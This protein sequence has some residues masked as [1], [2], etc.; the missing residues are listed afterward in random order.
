MDDLQRMAG[1]WKE[2]ISV[3]E[4]FDRT[5]FAAFLE[6]GYVFSCDN[7]TY[8]LESAPHVYHTLSEVQAL[9]VAETLEVVQEVQ[10]DLEQLLRPFGKVEGIIGMGN[11]YHYRHKV[12]AVFDRDHKGN[13]LA[14]AYQENT[15]QVVSTEGCLI[16][17]KESGD[18]H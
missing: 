2:L 1:G 3:S 5:L 12:H 10:Q 11:P 6:K 8:V 13:I 7:R 4:G 9:A 16:E 17:N 18:E 14:G 15:H